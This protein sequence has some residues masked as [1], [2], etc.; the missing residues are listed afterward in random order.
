[1]NDK[2]ALSKAKKLWGK[3]ALIEKMPSPHIGRNG[4]VLTGTHKVGV[5]MDLVPSFPMF[6]VRGN[7]M[8]WK[9][10]FDNYESRLK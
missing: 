7:G 4:Q 9:E 6:E 2:Q 1:M 10:A 3:K 8:N 5:L